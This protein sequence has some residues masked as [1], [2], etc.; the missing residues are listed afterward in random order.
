MTDEQDN[1]KV[2]KELSEAWLR[3]QH[4][5]EELRS[6]VESMTQLAHARDLGDSLQ[7]DLETAYRNLGQAVFEAVTSGDFSV[8]SKLHSVVAALVTVQDAIRQHHADV[9]ELLA[10]GAEAA[11]RLDKKP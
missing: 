6:K 4:Q 5:L 11:S 1:Q 9:A 10:E 2:V 3:A 8:P 7:D